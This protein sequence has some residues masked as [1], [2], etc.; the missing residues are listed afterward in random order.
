MLRIGV[1]GFPLTA[2]KGGLNAIKYAHEIGLHHIELEFVQAVF[3]KAE[4]A[5]E[6]KK[7]AAESDISLTAHGSYYINL[8]S[9]DPGK[10]HA[11]IERISK[12]AA[13]GVLAGV[14]SV[15]YHSGFYQGQAPE[16]A[17][18][19][20]LEYTGR[21]MAQV[22]P[23]INIAPELTGKP[24]QVGDLD[25]LIWLVSQ[26]REKGHAN[27]SLCI[28]FAHNFARQNGKDND[29][30]AFMGM[31]EKVHTKLGEATIKNLHIH[32]SGIDYSEK[33]E[34]NHLIFLPTLEAYAAEGIKVEGIEPHFQKLKANRLDPNTFNWKDLMKALKKSGVE[35]YVVCES[36][37]LEL[38]ALLMQK[39]YQDLPNA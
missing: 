10:Y 34:K 4:D 2:P 12:A 17:H 9:D 25:T 15:T 36:P 5:P 20:V 18:A 23:A 32:V 11:S 29:Y 26:L 24:G 39:Y 19:N 3:L 38:D 33:G 13:V 16:V 28:D 6:M 37:I 8:A 14:K 22:D 35:G 30:D 7:V 1:G 31:I 21:L 27:F